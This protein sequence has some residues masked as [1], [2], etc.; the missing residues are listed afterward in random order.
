MF[1]NLRQQIDLLYQRFEICHKRD[2]TIIDLV[3]PN[4]ETGPWIAGGSVLCWL[5]QEPVREHDI[6]IFVRDEAQYQQVLYRLRHNGF[7]IHHDSGNAVTLKTYSAAAHTVQVVKFFFESVD[8]LLTRFDF[9]VCAV[10]TDGDKI[11]A[12]PQFQKDFEAKVLRLQGEL[13]EDALKRIVKYIV[14]G[15]MPTNELL[16]AVYAK[17]DL[18]NTFAQ[19][20]YNFKI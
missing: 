4:L 19:D 11:H 10:A 8:D 13:K 5:N 20:Q 9:T 14:Y 7:Q 16:D 2:Q 1:D 17:K 15:Y 3:K 6:D 12:V 18:I